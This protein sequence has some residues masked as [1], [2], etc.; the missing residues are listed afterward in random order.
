MKTTT[1]A[2]EI[3]TAYGVKLDTP[4]KFSGSFQ[5]LEVSPA[6][7]KQ[8]LKFEL[9]E[10]ADAIPA[11]QAPTVG[12]LY[13]MLNNSEKANERQKALQSAL[14]VAGIKKPTLEDP[15]VQLREMIKIF[16]GAGRSDEEAEKAARGALGL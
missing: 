12:D 8:A 6:A 1:F 10:G 7:A 14:D 11:A 15:A 9:P 4:I 5:E 16:K 3:A 13:A 2:G